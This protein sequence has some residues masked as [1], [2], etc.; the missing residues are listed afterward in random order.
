MALIDKEYYIVKSHKDNW[1]KKPIK[2][3]LS[4]L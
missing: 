2:G 3:G 4:L 1:F